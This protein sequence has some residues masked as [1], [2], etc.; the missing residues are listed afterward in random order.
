[1]S[2]YF[3]K[4]QHISHLKA[5]LSLA[6][7]L[8][9]LSNHLVIS[10]PE[11]QHYPNFPKF[12]HGPLTRYVKL[13]IAHAPGMPG[14]FS[15]PPWV[16]D[17][18][19]HHGT[20]V[21]HV[22]WCIPG[23]LTVGFL[24]SRWRGKRSWHS[25]CMRNP[26][27]TSGKRPMHSQNTSTTPES[28]RYRSKSITVTSHWVSWDLGSPGIRLFVHQFVLA[29]NKGSASIWLAAA[30]YPSQRASNG[31]S[32]SIQWRCLQWRC[33]PYSALLSTFKTITHLVI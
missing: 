6:E 32:V 23:S 10:V 3:S 13:W 25:R 30:V 28:S 29:M 7:W 16:S 33:L 14:K 24:W 15:P 19:M 22:P 27:L 4:Q 8:A 18:G 21:T 17:P 11:S 12:E 2:H 31:E 26:H 9:A 5:L 20:C 1:M